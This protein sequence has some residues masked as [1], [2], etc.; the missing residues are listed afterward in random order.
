MPT[1]IGIKILF[2]MQFEACTKTSS[3]GVPGFESSAPLQQ[4]VD[5][6]AD[7]EVLDR[8][9]YHAEQKPK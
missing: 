7:E 6:V 2:T 8:A 5:E 3:G 9:C 4:F 1:K